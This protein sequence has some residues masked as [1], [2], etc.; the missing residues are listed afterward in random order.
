MKTI[1]KSG[2]SALGVS[3]GRVEVLSRQKIVEPTPIQEQA[4]PVALTGRDVMG[5]AQT[6]TGKTLAFGL[7]IA[8]NLRRG[9]SALV[10]APTRELAYQICETLDLLGLRMVVVVGGESM[11]KQ[12]GALRR[13]YD[14]IVA[15]PGRL[16]DHM[17]QRTVRFDRVRTV[18]LDEADRMLDMGFA[19]AIEKILA[20]CPKERQ[21]LLFSATM[22]AS[23]EKLAG[24]YLNRPVKVEVSRAWTANEMVDQ[25]VLY[26]EHEAKRAELGRLLSVD[27]GTV[28]VFTRTKHGARK[29]T[30]A[31]REDGVKAAEIHANRTLAQ[32]REALEGFKDGRYRVLVATDIAARGIDVKE[33]SMV[34]NFDV[35]E[36]SE[37]YVHRIGRTGRAGSTGYAVTLALPG[38]K[39]LI[40]AIEKLMGEKIEVMGSGPVSRSADGGRAVPM[41]GDSAGKSEAV[42]SNGARSGSGGGLVKTEFSGLV[43]FDKSGA[44]RHGKKRFWSGPRSGSGRPGGGSG[45]RKDFGPKR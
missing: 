22:P 44:P 6:G 31:L 24:R 18:V 36:H 27:S 19:P 15:T 7:P 28:L 37:D 11:G 29:L 17:Q 30:K 21:T 13:P 2:F 33:I 42:R 39:R 25:R 4:I 5:L 41:K 32:R 8:E 16:M 26:V 34:V 45:R 3:S 9:E 43:S 40:A 12:V 14:V 10:L 38:Q 20:V 23:I 1:L 35:P